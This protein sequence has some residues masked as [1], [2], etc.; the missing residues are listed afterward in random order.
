MHREKS[1]KNH[2]NKHGLSYYE[3][4]EYPTANND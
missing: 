3:G 2:W 1:I 4:L